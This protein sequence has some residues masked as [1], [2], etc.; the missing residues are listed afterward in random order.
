M[1]LLV[2]APAMKN[3]RFNFGEHA[4]SIA[5][6]IEKSPTP[7]AISIDGE[8]GSGKTTLMRQIMRILKDRNNT[9]KIIEF[10]A[11]KYER[12][13]LF[14]SLLECVKEQFPN[15]KNEIATVIM[16]LSLDL[17]LRKTIGMSKNEFDEHL[18]K[19]TSGMNDIED[20]LSGTVNERLVILIDDL[21]RCSM[22]NVLS[23]LES[24][25]LFLMIENIVIVIAVDMEKIE[26]AW[27]LRYRDNDATDIGIGYVEKL[28]QMKLTVPDKNKRDLKNYITSIT[29]YEENYVD[30]LV[31]IL[32]PNLRKIKQALNFLYF[33]L[34]IAKRVQIKS[35]VI[36]IFF[37]LTAWFVIKDSH[38][39]F[40][41][42]V[43]KDP[44]I[45]VNL[46]YLCSYYHSHFRFL[47]MVER[48][49]ALRKSQSIDHI[50][51]EDS[52]L[53]LD[54]H[55]ITENLLD[56]MEVYATDPK[57][58][59]ILHNF[60]SQFKTINLTKESSMQADDRMVFESI[61]DMF[62][63]VVNNTRA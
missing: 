27:R 10:D 3:L 52:H 29:E 44:N 57:I 28:F 17:V 53:I 46:A 9:L 31:G 22:E 16:N 58:F 2:D 62:K 40:A 18:E 25:K 59:R 61:C 56:A 20:L 24:M 54:K 8:W 33:E 43:R 15:R 42:V 34:F 49:S 63:D 48:V 21:D 19:F 41:T 47:Q 23:M 32:P 51:D 39:E 5:D 60:G 7:F 6:L 1:E 50:D 36:D 35:R 55:Y 38:R 45:F 37:A 14:T 26:A 11:W 4:K 30:Y 12:I 13:D